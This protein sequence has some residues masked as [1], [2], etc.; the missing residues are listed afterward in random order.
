MF[1]TLFSSLGSTLLSLDIALLGL[2]ANSLSFLGHLQRLHTLKIGIRH[3]TRESFFNV[4]AATNRLTLLALNKL[5]T[6]TN[7]A[8]TCG[9][10][11]FIFAMPCI[12]NLV[13]EVEMDGGVHPRDLLSPLQQTSS[14]GKLSSI[15]IYEVKPEFEVEEHSW[16]E[17]TMLDEV[18]S[19]LETRGVSDE[20]LR[21][22][23][24][25]YPD[26]KRLH[27]RDDTMR[28]TSATLTFAGVHAALQIEQRVEELTLRFAA[29]TPVPNLLSSTVTSDFVYSESGGG[30]RGFTS[31][32]CLRS[33][34]MCT[35]PIN[36]L[37]RPMFI[38]WLFGAHPYVKEFYCFKALREG[39]E[40]VYDP[41]YYRDNYSTTT[42]DKVQLLD[43][44][45]YAATMFDRWSDVHAFVNEVVE[46]ID[47]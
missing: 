23:A 21:S 44:Q 43:S 6:V 31:R 1:H 17:R 19:W 46:K 42:R 47:E 37:G 4:P 25:G 12:E 29:M 3:S 27:L 26:L 39:I 35:S 5:N 13:V 2:S 24:S 14:H 41:V 40:A 33:L 38:E 9:K 30:I 10:A 11:L 18:H 20:A 36:S 7:S 34:D 28:Q 16:W 15:S 45:V 8:E 32:S 22:L